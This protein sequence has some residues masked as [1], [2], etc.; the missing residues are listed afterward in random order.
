MQIELIKN[1]EKM[2]IDAWKN[3]KGITLKI[4]KYHYNVDIKEHHTGQL[5]KKKLS[6]SKNRYKKQH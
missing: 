6:K 2:A 3:T 5:N 1:Q 4:T